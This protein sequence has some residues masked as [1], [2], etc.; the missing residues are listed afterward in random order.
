[1][2]ELQAEVACVVWVRQQSWHEPIGQQQLGVGLL[3]IGHEHLQQHPVLALPTLQQNE[4]DRFA[5][6]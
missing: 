3:P 4:V 6:M 2:L 5:Q 1:M